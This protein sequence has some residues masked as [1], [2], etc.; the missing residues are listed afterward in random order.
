M[1][2]EVIT[3]WSTPGSSGALNVF[4][5]ENEADVAGFRADLASA[6]GSMGANLA[7]SAQWSIRQE[8]RTLD[9][10]TGALNGVWADPTVY[11]G[12]GIPTGMP[13]ASATQVLL[14]WTTNTIAG[15]RRVRGRTY[16]PGLVS[17]QVT[18]GELDPT[19][20]GEFAS[21]AAALAAT[22]ASFCVWHRPVAGIGGEAAPVVAGSCWNELAVQRR[23]R[24]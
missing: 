16:I 21:A 6:L 5:V 4:Y 24:D 14:Q 13:V 20:E 10:A 3:D 17:S 15:G 9:T 8:G 12:Q 22:T 1:V 11:E 7:Q 23:R 18:S 19:A 2:T